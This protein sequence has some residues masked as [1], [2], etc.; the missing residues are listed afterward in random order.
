MNRNTE[1]HFAR[2]PTM[3]HP[4]SVFDRSH[5]HKTTFNAGDIIPCYTAEVLPGDSVSLSMSKIVRAQTMLAPVYDNMYLDSYFFFVPN[6]IIWDHWKEFMGE[7][8]QSAWIP[9]VEYTVPTIAAPSGGFAKGTIADHMGYP[10][11][12]DWSNDAMNAPIVLPFRAYAEICNSFFRDQ[13]LSDPLVISTGDANQ[14]GSNGSG[15]SDVALGG[16]P[17]KAA[18]YHDYYTSCLPQPQKGPAVDVPVDW[19]LRLPVMTGNIHGVS[20]LNDG[21]TVRPIAALDYLGTNSGS[22]RKWDE[23]TV[24]ESHDHTSGSWSSRPTYSQSNMTI[25]DNGYPQFSQTVNTNIPANLW[26]EGSSALVG[27]DATRYIGFDISALRLAT[28]TQMYYEALARSGSRYEEQIETFFGIR[29][30]DSRMNHPEYLG[31]NRIRINVHEITNTAQSETDF[32]GDIGAKSVTTDRSYQFAKSFTEH[33]WIIG[34][35]VIRYDHSYCQGM[36]AQFMRK[37]KF[38]YYNPMFARIGEQPVKTAEIYYDGF[39]DSEQVFGYQEAWAS[40]RYAPNMAT[41]ELRPNV[42]SNLGSW[43][44]TDNY[45]QA[46]TLSD[47]WI[48]E[49]KTNVDRTL[50][51]TSSLADQFFADFY[52]D[53]KWTRVIPMFSVPGAIGQF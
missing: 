19:S 32:L 16:M 23:A 29:N 48:R 7:N 12:V 43:T 53:A 30:P 14:T 44:L 51:V 38:S 2:V 6:R 9:Q 35:C 45:A 28:I 27:D 46:P 49:D 13:N 36:P 8:T 39:S 18:K 41:G 33:G 40:Y 1:S 24:Y 17:Y 5:S 26:A 37:D 47:G 20:Q 52:F 25:S 21:G 42:Q 10:V 34:V 4:R 11:N 15:L 22:S 3:S 31:G 50:A